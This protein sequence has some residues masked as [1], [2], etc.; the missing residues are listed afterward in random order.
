MGPNFV[1]QADIAFGLGETP[2]QSLRVFGSH[3]IVDRVEA[4]TSIAARQRLQ[5]VHH[6]LRRLGAKFHAGAVEA[7]ERAM[8]FRSPPAAPLRADCSWNIRFRFARRNTP[9]IPARA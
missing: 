8:V 4:E 9:R 5:H 7:A 2:E 6:L 1:V 3:D